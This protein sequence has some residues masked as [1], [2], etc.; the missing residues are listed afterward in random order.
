[1]SYTKSVGAPRLSL[2]QAPFHVVSWP[3]RLLTWLYPARAMGR[4][5]SLDR[6]PVTDEAK[7]PRPAPGKPVRQRQ[8]ESL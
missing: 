4:D 8:G 3:G 5:R 2:I 6:G 7:R 1:V